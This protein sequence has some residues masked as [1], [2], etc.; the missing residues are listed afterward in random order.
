MENTTG[1]LD[2]ENLYRINTGV[3]VYPDKI[4]SFLDNYFSIVYNK[5]N[6][7]IVYS[8]YFVEGNYF[9]ENNTHY[10]YSDIICPVMCL[11]IL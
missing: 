1:I 7:R 8:I 3:G 9:E 10:H 6:H 5:L 2:A 4:F 11:F